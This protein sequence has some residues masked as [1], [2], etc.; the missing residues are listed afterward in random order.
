MLQKDRR[1]KSNLILIDIPGEKPGNI[2]M[3]GHLDKQP[4]MPILGCWT[5]PWN[6]VLKNEKLYG[7]WWG[8]VWIRN[9]CIFVC[10]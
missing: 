8:D 3:Y 7:R 5:R 9:F 10:A 2:L 1:A 6:P 4:E